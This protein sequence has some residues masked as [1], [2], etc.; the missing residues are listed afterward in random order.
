[1]SIY[2]KICSKCNTEKPSGEFSK[3]TA[4]KDGLQP[5]SKQCKNILNRAWSAN[6]S[7]TRKEY[8]KNY[9]P[10][11]Y[12]ENKENIRFKQKQYRSEHISDNNARS[13]KRH[14]SKLQATPFWSETKQNQAVYKEAKRLELETGI[15]QHVDHIVPLISDL[16]CGL[17]VLANLRIIPASE[18]CSKGNHHWP[19][20]P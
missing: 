2:T 18:N 17:H 9:N 14:A 1:M 3:R 20:M 5:S 19:D 8:N 15:K 13:A 10:Q 7:G 11:Y 16:V 4:S 6:N 12:S